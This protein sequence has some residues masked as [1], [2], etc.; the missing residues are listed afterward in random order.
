M[1]IGSRTSSWPSMMNSWRRTC[2]ICWS[3]G[4]F[5]AARRVDGAL[6]VERVHLAVL[7]RH[8]AG[9]V[10]A[11]DVAAGDA[12]EG[13]GDLGVGHQLGFLE[14]ALH[15][16]DGGLDVHHHA[17]LQALRLVPAPCR[18]WRARRRGAARPPGRRPSRCRCPERRSG[19]CSLLA[20]AQPLAPVCAA[21][22]RWDSA[23]RR[24][25]AALHALQGR[26]VGADEAAQTRLRLVAVASEH[27]VQPVAQRSCQAR[28]WLSTTRSGTTPS[29]AS[30]ALKL[31]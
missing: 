22:S 15:R 23:G 16:A 27:D 5:T 11:A 26:F 12:D 8:H 14:R 25:R 6:D 20:S 4:M 28:R 21:Q 31:A 19:S 24:T 18:G 29:G 9:R 1:P 7:D 10:E 3:V 13:R 30:S 2:R 17:L